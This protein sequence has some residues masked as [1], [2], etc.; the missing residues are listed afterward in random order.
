MKRLNAADFTKK[1]EKD[2]R[3]HEEVRKNNGDNG[4]FRGDYEIYIKYL[5]TNKT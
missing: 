2:T 3:I 1:G 4:E 5:P